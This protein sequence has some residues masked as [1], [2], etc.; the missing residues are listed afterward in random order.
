MQEKAEEKGLRTHTNNSVVL[1]QSLRHP[2]D[3][4]SWHKYCK[5]VEVSGNRA[6]GIED[7]SE[8]ADC[9]QMVHQ[10]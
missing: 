10:P 9:A 4:V 3:E 7:K 6:D 2:L 8:L 1:L 5:N